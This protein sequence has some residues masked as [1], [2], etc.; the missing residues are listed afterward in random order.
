MGC[1]R[2]PGAGDCRAL[3]TPACR[4][5]GPSR[6]LYGAASR[7]SRRANEKP[8]HP[9]LSRRDGPEHDS[10]PPRESLKLSSLSIDVALDQC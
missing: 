5:T 7:L 3:D 1:N 6:F 10:P 9:A 2:S 8:T 4:C